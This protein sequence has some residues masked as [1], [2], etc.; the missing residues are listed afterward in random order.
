MNSK[1]KPA[2]AG[3]APAPSF[4]NLNGY[5]SKSGKKLFLLAL[6]AV[7]CIALIHFTGLKQYLSNIHDLKDQL[8]ALGI[9]GPV[10]FTSAV[11]MLVAV[12]APR[13]IFCALGGL[14][15]GFFY[16]LIWSQIGTLAGSYL[17]FV[18][19][20][21]GGKEWVSRKLAGV[22]SGKLKNIIAN[23]SVFSVF[24]AMQIPV[25][26]FFINLFL[27]VTSVGTGTFLVGSML[28]FLPEAVVVTLIGSGL[29]KE[30]TSRA[31]LQVIVAIVCAA[32]V[33]GAALLRKRSRLESS[34]FKVQS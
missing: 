17:T 4:F 18:C 12:G 23:P 25:G 6:G 10:V 9:W 21:W 26:G 14:A 1:P 28:G 19:A 16:G 2:S 24:L 15:F 32:I 29:G 11:A 3:S 27:G 33:L 8:R 30:T 20:R 5:L 34:K 13:L 7:A 22:E 31:L